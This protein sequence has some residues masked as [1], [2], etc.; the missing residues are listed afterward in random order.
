MA[1]H[2][3]G[4]QQSQ[5]AQPALPYS[6]HAGAGGSLGSLAMHSVAGY[7]CH[8]AQSGAYVGYGQA[9]S[10]LGSIPGHLQAQWQQAQHA[11]TAQA[12]QITQAAQQLLRSAQQPGATMRRL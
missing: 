2:A 7:G 4:Q 5:H 10:G 12:A 9:I 6:L 3:H 8:G 11:Q 1:S